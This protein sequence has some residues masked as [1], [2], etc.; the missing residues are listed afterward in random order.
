M[1]RLMLV[2]I[3]FV[4]GLLPVPS[5][6]A[7]A[8]N[9][10][11][12]GIL[13][14]AFS[15]DGSSVLALSQEGRFKSWDV[16]SGAILSQKTI[17][18]DFTQA[19]MSRDGK[20]ILLVAYY[21][22]AIVWDL[23][24]DR[25]IKTFDTAQNVFSVAISPDDR[26]VVVGNMDDET[27]NFWDLNTGRW[28]Y[29][30]GGHKEPYSFHIT[31]IDI[32][33]DGKLVI[34]GDRFNNAVVWDLENQSIL[35]RFVGTVVAF[36]PDSRE[37]LNG[38]SLGSVWIRDTKTREV[39]HTLADHTDTINSLAFSHDGRYVISASND[40]TV[41]LWDARTGKLLQTFTH[42]NAATQARL[43]LDNTLVISGDVE[44]YVYL[45]DAKTGKQLNKWQV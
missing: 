22:Y 29:S 28:L 26:Y 20:Y 15:A 6:M 34:T 27:I 14:T 2:F 1:R 44:G 5:H 4:L 19:V 35:Q 17:G 33:S 16:K 36:S 21:R 38:T 37:V 8:L 45:W 7:R 12:K 42:D 3:C 30:L 40:K 39:L 18:T 13:L 32:S 31:S 9:P 10:Y 23:G 11:V 24:A 43:S 41:R 25:F